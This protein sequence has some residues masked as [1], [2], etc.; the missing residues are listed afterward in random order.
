MYTVDA[1]CVYM[2]H[3]ACMTVY[4]HTLKQHIHM[5]I[6]VLKSLFKVLADYNKLSTELIN[7]I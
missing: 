7:N 2:C 1:S 3:Y 6:Q 4:I 5:Y